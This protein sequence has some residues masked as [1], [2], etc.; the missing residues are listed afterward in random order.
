MKSRYPD[1]YPG[2]SEQQYWTRKEEEEQQLRQGDKSSEIIQMIFNLFLL[3]LKIGVVLG[4]FIFISYSLSKKIFGEEADQLKILGFT[5][6]LTYLI[7]CFVFFLKGI[8]IGLWTKGRKLWIIPWVICVLV[9]CIIPAYLAKE[10][11]TVMFQP[12]EQDSMW[13]VGLSWGAFVMALWYLD[14]IY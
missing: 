11:V 4:I 6:F 10:F 5:V 14:G 7:L 2:E 8:I 13:S 3:L 12:S 1:A 9:C